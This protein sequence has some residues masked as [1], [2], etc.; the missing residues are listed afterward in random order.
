MLPCARLC[1]RPGV[2]WFA[3]HDQLATPREYRLG[4]LRFGLRRGGRDSRTM[5]HCA[6]MCGRA[7]MR[8][9]AGHDQLTTLRAYISML[10]EL[11]GYP[12]GPLRL[13][14]CTRRCRRARAAVRWFAA[15]DRLTTL[16]DYLRWPL[17]LQFGGSAG[18][19]ATEHRVGHCARAGVDGGRWMVDRERHRSAAK[20][21]RHRRPAGGHGAHRRPEVSG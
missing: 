20:C 4:P 2:R 14:L 16:C 21:C 8:W 7:D 12:L 6:R 3:A 13:R 1:R 9:F 10:T 19:D 18:E 11:R 17:S 5:L 15:D